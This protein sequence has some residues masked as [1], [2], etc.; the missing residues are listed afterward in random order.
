MK[1]SHVQRT[2]MKYEGLLEKRGLGNRRRTNSEA[3]NDR[4]I[5]TKEYKAKVEL[6]G[7]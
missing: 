1:R 6:I 5:V 3:K 2:R 4:L 7:K